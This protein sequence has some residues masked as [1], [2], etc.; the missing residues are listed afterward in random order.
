MLPPFVPPDNQEWRKLWDVIR[1]V[2]P[3]AIRFT[4]AL[5]CL[6][7]MLLGERGEI[8]KEDA[9]FSIAEVYSDNRYDDSDQMEEIMHLAL[10]LEL[11]ANMS[12]E[13][14]QNLWS[15]VIAIAEEEGVVV[16][17]G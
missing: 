4:F 2:E 12:D 13:G 3:G 16:Q 9:A 17:A 5:F 1:Q 6:G 10:Q 8:A 15:L 14:W 11:P 7:M